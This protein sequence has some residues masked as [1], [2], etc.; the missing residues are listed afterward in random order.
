MITFVD[1]RK[2]FDS[3]HRDKMMNILSAY[4][5]PDELAKAISLL[6]ENTRAKILSP[7][8]DTEFFDTLADV[9]QGDAL[10]PYLFAIVIDYTVRQAVGDQE[11]DLGF[12]LDKRRSRR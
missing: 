1:F 11:L 10:A 3:V 5:I 4:G 7:N 2:A 8:G 12:K 9:L 6:Y